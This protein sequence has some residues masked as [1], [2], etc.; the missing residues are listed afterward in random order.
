MKYA[1]PY[2]AFDGSVYDAQD[3]RV[4]VACRAGD[5]ASIAADLNLAASVINEPHIETTLAVHRRDSGET[6][7]ASVEFCAGALPHELRAA[8]ATGR[9]AAVFLGLRE[10][11]GVSPFRRPS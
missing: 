5:A 9:D 6:I 3:R 2:R 4:L 10:G 8:I 11:A 7:R 1:G